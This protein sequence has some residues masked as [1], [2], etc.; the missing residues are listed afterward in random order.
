VSALWQWWLAAPLVAAA[1]LYAGWR[2]APA[3]LRTRLRRVLGI[4]A[5]TP[6]A[7]ACDNCSDHKH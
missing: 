3:A 1:A 4:K 6:A 2:L 5:P 7:G